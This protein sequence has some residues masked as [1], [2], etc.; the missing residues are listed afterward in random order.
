MVSV[1]CNNYNVYSVNRI[2]RLQPVQKSVPKKAV[3]TSSN[4]AFK[5]EANSVD[6]VTPPVNVRTQLI[7]KDEKKKYKEVSEALDN[8]YKKKLDY[9][10]KTGKLLKN[11]SNDN[12]SVLDNL[13]KI[14]K[15]DRDPGL[16]GRTILMECLE[17]FPL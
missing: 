5:A 1:N 8:K 7:T 16:D 13:H 2:D 9:A 3:K 17:V 10:L 11:D 4:P 12:S 14:I 6:L 15:E